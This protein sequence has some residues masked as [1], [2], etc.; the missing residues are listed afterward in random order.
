MPFSLSGT[1]GISALKPERQ[2]IRISRVSVVRH[3]TDMMETTKPVWQSKVFWINLLTLLVGVLGAIA[4]SDLISDNPQLAAW[5]ASAIAGINMVLRFFSNQ[6][7]TI[8]GVTR[9]RRS[10]KQF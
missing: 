4:G 7:V 2:V 9:D 3:E 1:A 8:S 6:P 10:M 5:L